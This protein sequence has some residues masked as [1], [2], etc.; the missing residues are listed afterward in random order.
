MLITQ[1]NIEKK[2]L[3]ESSDSVSDRF[4]FRTACTNIQDYPCHSFPWHWH[5]EAELLYVV[6][7]KLMVKIPENELI[8]SKG[9]IIFLP[10]NTLHSTQA[11]DDYPGVHMEYIFL[12]LFIG[13]FWNSILM[14]KYVLPLVQHD[15]KYIF[16]QNGAANSLQLQTLL[17][18]IFSLA[19]DEPAHYEFHIHHQLEAVWILLFDEA[20]SQAN[21]G[22]INHAN[23]D[24]LYKM[25]EFIQN[26][27]GEEIS[28]D[29]IAGAASISTRECN[30]CFK[31]SLHTT[32][33]EYLSEYRIKQACTLLIG[34]GYSITE[35]G[36]SCGFSSASYFAKRFR[37]MT[38]VTPK[39]YR[40]QKTDLYE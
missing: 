4:P 38:G 21:A 22:L 20:N 34:S 13:G 14:Q 6:E 7:G 5:E 16:I 36:Q 29:D 33:M 9:D 15:S 19:K 24:R 23:Q 17:T 25:L 8:L 39:E 18:N 35:I 3:R 10:S 1:T 26:H 31:N 27:Y 28:L 37:E 32:T 12:P 2:S 40:A 30:R 11:V